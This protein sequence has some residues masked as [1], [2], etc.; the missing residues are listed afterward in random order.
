V[1]PRSVVSRDVVDVRFGRALATR[2]SVCAREIKC[3]AVA[4]RERVR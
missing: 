1:S 3:V 4:E 2:S